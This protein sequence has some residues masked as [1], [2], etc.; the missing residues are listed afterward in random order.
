M[1]SLLLAVPER[2]SIACF[3]G[4]VRDVTTAML[5]RE[6]DVAGIDCAINEGRSQ[7]SEALCGSRVGSDS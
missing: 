6:G 7:S 2:G 1:A 4:E 3:W 5:G